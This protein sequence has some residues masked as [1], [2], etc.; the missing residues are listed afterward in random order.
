MRSR[1]KRSLAVRTAELA[2]GCPEVIGRR[3]ARMAMTGAMPGTKDRREL[4]RMGAEKV[5]A[6]AEAWNGM[7]TEVFRVNQALTVSFWRWYWYSWI[8]GRTS[9]WAPPLQSAVLSILNRGTAPF[10]R[11]VIANVKR[12]RRGG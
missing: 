12:L 6:F 7:A 10:H 5:S 11:R 1:R 8:P 4:H 3:A 9:G 2:L